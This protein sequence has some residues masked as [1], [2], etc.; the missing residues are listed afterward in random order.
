MSSSSSSKL[1]T[2][3]TQNQEVLQFPYSYYCTPYNSP[4]GAPHLPPSQRR[5]FYLDA[6]PPSSVPTKA[7]LLLLHGFP[8]SSYGWRHVLPTLSLSGYRCIVPDLVGYGRTSKPSRLE[9]YGA[10]SQAIDLAGLMSHAMGSIN[11]KF[12]VIGHDW[13]SWLSWKLANWIPDRLLG[14][15]GEC[16]TQFLDQCTSDLKLDNLFHT[17]GICIPYAPPSSKYISVTDLA[18]KMPQYGYQW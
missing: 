18:K 9:E 5:Y 11:A 17:S 14:V 7:T 16:H 13:G 15:H 8:D 3:Q 2:Y 1:T 10:H 12:A 6:S 4:P